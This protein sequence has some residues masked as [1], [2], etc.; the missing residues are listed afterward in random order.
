MWKGL[1]DLELR[2][3][4]MLNMGSER[5][6]GIR[7]WEAEAAVGPS[8]GLYHCICNTLTL[9]LIEAGLGGGATIIYSNSIPSYLY[10]PSDF[11]MKLGSMDPALV[12]SGPMSTFSYDSH[13]MSRGR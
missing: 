12:C 7:Q 13:P 2:R 6:W 8:T 10:F 4:W 9:T 5:A 1:L 3:G 11:S